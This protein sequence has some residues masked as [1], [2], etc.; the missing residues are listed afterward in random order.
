M[1]FHVHYQLKCSYP[2]GILDL[3][4]RSKYFVEVTARYFH[5]P[6]V[7]NLFSRTRGCGDLTSQLNLR[8]HC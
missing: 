7:W 3:S 1:K 4:I 6:W 2:I 5:Y 8:D